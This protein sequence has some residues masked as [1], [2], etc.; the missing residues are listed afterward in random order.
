ML[1]KTTLTAALLATTTHAGIGTDLIKVE[2]SGNLVVM[3]HQRYR[4]AVC[5]LEFNPA[6]PT[7]H[8]YGNF[9][10]QEY[11]GGPLQIKGY[12][13]RLPPPAS[14]HGLSFNSEMFD[15]RDCASTSERFADLDPLKDIIMGISAGYYTNAYRPTLFLGSDSISKRSMVVTENAG[16][17]P[18]KEIACCNVH[19]FRVYDFDYRNS[20]SRRGGRGRGH[21][22]RHLEEMDDEDVNVISMAEYREL[23]GEDFD[24]SEWAGD[25]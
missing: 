1:S 5:R 10:M 20:K 17:D 3:S 15:N 8:P 2:D 21:S 24:L 18:G 14:S 6:H 16:D 13:K 11:K 12:M 4:Y 19:V 25:F 7:S 23:Y 9:K 22:S